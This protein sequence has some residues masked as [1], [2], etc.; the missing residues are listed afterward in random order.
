MTPLEIE[1]L[2]DAI[3]ERLAGRLPDDDRLIDKHEAAALL[4]CSVPSIE[5]MKSDR[6]RLGG[7]DG[8][9]GLI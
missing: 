3:V 7:C 1:M 4:K 2:A 6:S 8:S 9:V 5:R